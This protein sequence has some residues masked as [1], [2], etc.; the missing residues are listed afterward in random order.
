MTA[1]GVVLHAVLVDVGDEEA[2]FFHLFDH[3][4]AR[5]EADRA[6]VQLAAALG[7]LGKQPGDG[8]RARRLDR[9][10]VAGQ[11]QPDGLLGQEHHHLL[12]RREARRRGQEGAGQRAA[13]GDGGTLRVETDLWSH[14]F[15]DGEPTTTLRTSAFEVP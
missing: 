15:G 12:A 13:E 1:L 10:G 14:T 9:V 11:G 4:L 3:E 7:E 5:V 6:S 2:Q 8:R